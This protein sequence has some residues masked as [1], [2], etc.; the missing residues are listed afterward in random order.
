MGG[1]KWPRIAGFRVVASWPEGGYARPPRPIGPLAQLAGVLGVLLILAGTGVV[2]VVFLSQRHAP[3]PSAAA[4]GAI[5]A[6]GHGRLVWAG[7][8]A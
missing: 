3:Q 8:L 6:A 5:A 4:A 7:R 1:A 2:G